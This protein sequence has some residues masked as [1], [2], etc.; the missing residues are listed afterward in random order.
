VLVGLVIIFL[1]FKMA[2]AILQAAVKVTAAI[3][4]AAVEVIMLRD[5]EYVNCF[6]LLLFSI[7]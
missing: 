5:K 1:F 4:W 6:H 2:V 7:C 3:L